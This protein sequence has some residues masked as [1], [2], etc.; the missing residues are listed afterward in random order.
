MSDERR[1]RKRVNLSVYLAV[2]DALM[3]SPLG[4]L[5]DLNAAGFLIIS[6]KDIAQ[7]GELSINIK[8]PEPIED[9]VY[10]NVI[11]KLIRSKPSSN[12]IYNES[13]FEITYA[14]SQTKRIIEVLQ[15][16][17]HLHFPNQ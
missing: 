4:N 17:W 16:H 5:I 9:L 14:S 12:P 1:L 15:Q 2:S 8:L 3:D 7:S 13:A 10:I 6:D 11:A